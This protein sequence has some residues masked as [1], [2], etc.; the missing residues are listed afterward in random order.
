MCQNGT[1]IGVATAVLALG[2]YQQTATK[3]SI[4]FSGV[5]YVHR[6]SK[7]NLNE[8]T[9]KK[10]ANLKT[11][12]DMLTINAYPDVKSGEDLAK[13]ANWVL[14]AY[15]GQGAHIVRTTSV[16]KTE[17]KKAEHLIVALFVRK[18]FQEV[19]FARL[20]MSGGKGFSIVYSH[21]S[22]GK[23]AGETMGKWLE[24]SGEKFEKALMAIPAIP[25]H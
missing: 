1:M 24:K 20:Q 9:P 13:T 21:R 4:T 22:Y 17:K 25:L 3:P 11:W 23:K 5:E 7:G 2:F 12:T 6:Y 14:E 10:Q 18:D 16:P 8:Y 19:G 15:K